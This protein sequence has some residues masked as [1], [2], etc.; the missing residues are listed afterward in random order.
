MSVGRLKELLLAS[1]CLSIS[2]NPVE[3]S[4]T[5]EF[6]NEIKKK[7]SMQTFARWASQSRLFGVINLT[8]RRRRRGCRV[9][10]RNFS[11]FLLVPTFRRL[12]ETRDRDR[13]FL[14]RL[15]NHHNQQEGNLKWPRSFLFVFFWPSS[16]FWNN[17]K[18]K[19]KKEDEKVGR[20]EGKSSK[21]REGDGGPL[22]LF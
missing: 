11:C 12:E 10:A 13:P 15:I 6:P 20:K 5:K 17:K 4:A 18:K 19:K 16:L 14:T 3:K 21:R 8:G 2:G 1:R 22:F 7:T 9:M